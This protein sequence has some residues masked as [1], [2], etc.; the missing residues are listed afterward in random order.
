MKQRIRQ[1]LAPQIEA[2]M[3][4]HIASLRPVRAELQA[5]RDRVDKLGTRMLALASD[6]EQLRIE[7][8]RQRGFHGKMTVHEAW[9][10]HPGVREVFTRYH[11]PHCDRCPVGADE[12]LEEAAFGYSLDLS[13]L[14]KELN[15]LC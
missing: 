3:R 9:A 14:L 13:V 8:L 11:L 10:L 12:R 15:D 1:V 2:Q 6:V 7:R 5:V 4:E